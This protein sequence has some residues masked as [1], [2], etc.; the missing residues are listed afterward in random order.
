M[1]A[2]T[3][4][5]PLAPSEQIFAFSEVFVGYCARMSGRLDLSA[6]AAAFEALVTAHPILGAQL[7]PTEPIG[8]TLVTSGPPEIVLTVADGDPE[9]LLT[10]AEPD[11]RRAL[12]TLHVVL[13]ED[14]AS[15]TLLV[16][17]SIADATHAL[18][19]LERLWHCYVSAAAGRIFSLPPARQP[20][21][22]EDLLAARG[23]VR[24]PVP[25]SDEPP[26]AL[27]PLPPAQALNANENVYPPLR[28]TRC[29]LS[30]EQS[31]D[32][33]AYGHRAGVTV[34]SLVA[35]ALLLTE[36]EARQLPVD[37]L[38]CSYSVDLRRRVAP[39]I[40]PTEGTNVLGF[41]GYRPGPGTEGTLTALAHGVFH[42]LR[43][44]L[45]SGYIQQTPLQLPDTLAA[46]PANPFDTV[47]T[48]NWG[49]L[50]RL[51]VPTL[52]IH[53]F[54]TTMIAKPDPTGRRPP[55]AG[56]GTSIISTYDDR[57]SVEIHH[58]PEFTPV[59]TPRIERLENL[60][61]RL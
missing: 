55:Q 50:P 5:R 3:V 57:L 34:H 11:Q 2:A 31:T 48:T 38:L 1:T 59:Q 18:N 54:R 33:V 28:T 53:D 43:T 9:L 29:R 40:G 23:I 20:M 10:G 32:L 56:G 19:L 17:H 37:E 35:A 16:H 30:R 8:H 14:M 52:R 39:R 26:R 7:A 46:P 22:V 24:R 49:R 41:A 6:L 47:M 13:S 42:A 27:P 25:G 36:S 58:P 4:I 61:T 51:S 21:P 15:V 60:L 12:G 44:G 45:T